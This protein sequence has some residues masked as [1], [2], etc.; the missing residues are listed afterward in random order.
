M[1]ARTQNYTSSTNSSTNQCHRSTTSYSGQYINGIS[2]FYHSVDNVACSGAM[3]SECY[4]APGNTNSQGVA[5]QGENAQDLA[6]SPATDLVTITVGINNVDFADVLNTCYGDNIG[7]TLQID[8][9]NSCFIDY[10]TNPKGI[11]GNQ[12]LSDSFDP[13]NAGYSQVAYDLKNLLGY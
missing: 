2:G 6:L 9:I 13:S 7:F 8:K 5:S 10:L 4:F 1:A 3:T 12:T 11:F